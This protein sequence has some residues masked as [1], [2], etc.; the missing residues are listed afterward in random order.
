MTDNDPNSRYVMM[1]A[2]TSHAE[3]SAILAT[4]LNIPKDAIRGFAFVIAVDPAA[5]VPGEQQSDPN[6]MMPVVRT[7]MS[8][9]LTSYLLSIAI[10]ETL[11]REMTGDDAL[12]GFCHC[13]ENDDPTQPNVGDAQ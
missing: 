7:S 12:D 4:D 13:H 1:G 6:V 2:E 8:P 3:M 5:V 11:L 10:S 9:R